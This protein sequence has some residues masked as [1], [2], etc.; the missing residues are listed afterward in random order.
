M[1]VSELC[2]E[3]MAEKEPVSFSLIEQS[4]GLP[5]IKKVG[6]GWGWGVGGGQRAADL[7]GAIQGSCAQGLPYT[8]Q[9]HLKLPNFPSLI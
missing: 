6:G 3:L 8:G 4:L 7:P 1:S 5:P 9:I 2:Q